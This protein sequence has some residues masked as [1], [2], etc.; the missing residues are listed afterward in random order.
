[1]GSLIVADWYDPGVGGHRMGDSN[2]GRLF[3]LTVDAH[4]QYRVPQ[5]DFSTVTGA[6]EGLAS[7]NQSTRY[8]AGE[9]LQQLWANS[10]PKV[11]AWLSSD[12]TASPRMRARLLWQLARVSS[13][14]EAAIQKGLSDPDS[15]VRIAAIRAARQS[16]AVSNL[17]VAK[18]MVDDTSPQVRREVAI[19]LRGET[20][21]EAASVWTKLALMHDGQDR[22]Y[23]EAL[24]IG[25]A[26]QWDSFFREWQRQVGEDWNQPRHHDIIWRARTPA[27]CR[28]LTKIIAESPT[29][30]LQQRYFRALD[31]HSGD[32]K[33]IAL[34]SLV[35]Q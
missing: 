7:P 35:A 22:W 9:S 5:I 27:A 21:D 25:A 1:D 30:E 29:A 32:E 26:K 10:I 20:S 13:V 2:R 8:L 4:R 17:L 24:G 23:L 3:R 15:N 31:F 6:V 14:S 34:K 19:L 28:Y 16:K 33:R 18:E 12:N 11:D